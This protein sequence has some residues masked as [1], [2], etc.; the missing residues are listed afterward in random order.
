[1]PEFRGRIYPFKIHLL[2]RLPTCVDE[3]R[4]AE[5]DDSLFD[6]RDGAFEDDEVVFYFAV[7]DEASHTVKFCVSRGKWFLRFYSQRLTV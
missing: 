1:M 4:F 3:H 7:A 5:G 2:Q 6:A